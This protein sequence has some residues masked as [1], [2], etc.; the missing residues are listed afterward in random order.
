MSRRVVTL[1]LSFCPPE[2]ATS[3]AFPV[4]EAMNPFSPQPVCLEGLV[5]AT[6]MSG[7]IYPSF[8]FPSESLEVFPLSYH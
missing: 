1:Q 5:I 3:P 4:T 6:N 7:I 8:E 2:P